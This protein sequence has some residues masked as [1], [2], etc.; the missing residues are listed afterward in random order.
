MSFNVNHSKNFT[1]EESQRKQKKVDLHMDEYSRAVL[2]YFP[3][4]EVISTT[5]P[6]LN[7][8]RDAYV[9]GVMW[10]RCALER[11]LIVVRVQKGSVLRGLVS[12]VI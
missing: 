4:D 12:L 10:G 3:H 6:T 11:L 9:V 2:S 1:K 5:S 8:N 7:S